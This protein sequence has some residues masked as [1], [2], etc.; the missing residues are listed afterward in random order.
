MRRC[1]RREAAKARQVYEATVRLDADFF[2]DRF[3]AGLIDSR[4]VAG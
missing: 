1:P 3:G 2:A 4:V